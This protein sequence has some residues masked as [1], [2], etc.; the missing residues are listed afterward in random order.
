MESESD[1]MTL[2]LLFIR[3]MFIVRVSKGFPDVMSSLIVMFTL[4]DLMRGL[5]SILAAVQH[6]H[7]KHCPILFSRSLKLHPKT[8]VSFDKSKPLLCRLGGPYA[9]SCSITQSKIITT[10]LNDN[11]FGR[12]VNYQL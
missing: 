6:H 9:I 5:H 3:T 7:L 2:V 11:F 10:N 4:I 12:R 8:T 1:P